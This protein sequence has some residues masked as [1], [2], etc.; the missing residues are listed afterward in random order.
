MKFTDEELSEL[1][2]SLNQ[3][4]SEDR[5]RHTLGVERAAVALGERCLP[6]HISQLRA[7][8]LLHDVAKELSFEKLKEILGQTSDI[9]ESDYLSPP[10]FHSLA[11]PFIIENDYPKFATSDILR[12]VRYHTTASSD[13]TVFDEIIFVADFIEDTRLYSA[14]VELRDRLMSQIKASNSTEE[15]IKHL[16]R[17]VVWILEFTVEY[18]NSK[19]KYINERTV[20]ASE[21]LSKRCSPISTSVGKI[22]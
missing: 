19:N 21:V 18:L 1:K 9:T 11:A 6:T 5:Y 8:A 4:L 14:S 12:A 7:A 2:E 17:A 13:M 15:S 22:K 20:V 10:I 3:R 16:H